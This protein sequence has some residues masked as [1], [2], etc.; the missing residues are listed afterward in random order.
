[1]KILVSYFSQT[2]NTEKIAK[3]IYE[4]ASQG[5]Q[6]DLKKLED[7]V[8]G[9]SPDMMSFS[10]APPSTPVIWPHRSKIF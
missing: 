10:S 7:A 8:L 6:A 1:M 9:I 3:G 2:G 5:N 4:E